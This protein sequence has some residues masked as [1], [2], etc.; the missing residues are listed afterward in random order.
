MV[1]CLI[2]LAVRWAQLVFGLDPKSRLENEAAANI[3]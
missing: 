3:F 2:K 1:N